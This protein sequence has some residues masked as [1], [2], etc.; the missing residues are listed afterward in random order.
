MKRAGKSSAEQ[1]LLRYSGGRSNF[2]ERSGMGFSHV[3]GAS[4]NKALKKK[5][6]F[7]FAVSSSSRSV[8]C[9]TSLCGC[10][11]GCYRLVSRFLAVLFGYFLV[12]FGT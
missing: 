6:I 8:I 10:V 4:W 7:F 1:H 12:F 2:R 11:C 9:V 3:L 5:I